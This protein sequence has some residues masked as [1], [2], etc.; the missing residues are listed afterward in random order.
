MI[1]ALGEK[2]ALMRTAIMSAL[3]AL[4]GKALSKNPKKWVYWWNENR[5]DF[6]SDMLEPGF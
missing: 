2:G 4:T 1:K 5:G 6:T 3:K